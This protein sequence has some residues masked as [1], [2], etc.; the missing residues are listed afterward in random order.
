MS[1][2][3]DLSETSVVAFL[4]DSSDGSWHPVSEDFIFVNSNVIQPGAVSVDQAWLEIPYK[5]EKVVR[6]VAVISLKNPKD[7]VYGWVATDMVS[8]L[9]IESKMKEAPPSED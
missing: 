8:L 5:G 9:D 4:K 7:G 1:V 6:L 2:E 3:I